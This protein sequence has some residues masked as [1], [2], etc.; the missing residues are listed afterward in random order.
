[1][2]L[3]VTVPK[4]LWVAWLLEG[5]AA[6]Q[7]ETGEEWVFRTYGQ[8]PTAEP[9]DRLYI[10]AWNLVRGYAPVTRVDRCGTGNV[11]GI[12]RKA[13]A[14]A[15]T[16]GEEVIGFRGWRRRW[17]DRALETPF[18]SW[19]TA[20]LPKRELG[21]VELVRR[22][23]VPLQCLCGRLPDYLPNVQPGRV[24]Y[25][26]APCGRILRAIAGMLP[27]EMPREWNSVIEDLSRGR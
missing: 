21:F 16:I 22:Q 10:V 27:G 15:C 11:W 3:V 1:M 18:P 12:F 26:C 8:R 7:P 2:D 25:G 20:C 14:V 6:G 23:R 4:A 17:W 5:D 19:E 13:G 9:G 24:C